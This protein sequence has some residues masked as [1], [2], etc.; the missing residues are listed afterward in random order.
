MALYQGLLNRGFRVVTTEKHFHDHDETWIILSGKGLAYWID[1]N[2][3]REDFMLAAGDVWM[4]P[5][6]YEHGSD[7]FPETGRN[8]DDFIIQV[9]YGT[10]PPGA[11]TPGHYYVEKEG[12]IPSLT[13][14][15]TPTNRYDP[16]SLPPM[17]KGIMFIEKGRAALIDEETPRCGPGLALC[18]TLFTGLTNGTERNTLMGGNYSRGWPGRAGYQSV[19]RVLAVGAGVAGFAEGDVVFHGDFQQHRQY[20][21]GPAGEQDLILKLPKRAH[22]Q[23]AALFGVASV[24]LHDVRRAEV[25]LG[26]RVLVVGAGLIGQFTSQAALACGAIVTVCDLNADRLRVAAELGAHHTVVPD[27]DWAN[28]K[29][30]GPFDCVFEDSGA[31][32]L[33]GI[34]GRTW[35]QGI[36]KLRGRLV[37]IAGRG[38]VDYNF[39]AAQGDEIAVHHASHFVLD[40]LRETCRLYLEGRIQIAPLLRD[41]VHF[42]DMP[43]LYDRLRDAPDSLLG[44]VFDWRE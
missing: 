13:L 42:R 7:G 9:I 44:V 36:L 3:R 17:M 24:A 11:H 41:V 2:G 29:A 1:H 16:P 4:I 20:F 27:D 34:V 23:H 10:L 43:A 19:G 37:M 15:R 31:P 35:N 6:G 38:R 33:D 12:Y 40:D 25:K 26:E 39:N 28:I 32:V 22:P 5:A 14:N 30:L 21:A 18:Q 8:S